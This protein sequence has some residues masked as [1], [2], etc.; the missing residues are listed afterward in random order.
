M[1]L[2]T[3]LKRF[4][5]LLT[6]YGKVVV[7]TYIHIIVTKLRVGD[8][9]W[10]LRLFQNLTHYNKMR[11]QFLWAYHPFCCKYFIL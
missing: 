4:I 5:Y 8:L 3:L 11:L 1:L 7:T 10:N 9:K 6:I 2:F